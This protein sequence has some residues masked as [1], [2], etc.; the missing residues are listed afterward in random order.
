MVSPFGLR[1]AVSA[2]LQESTAHASAPNGL[3][4]CAGSLV[5]SALMRNLCRAVVVLVFAAGCAGADD[6]AGAGGGSTDPLVIQAPPGAW[7]WI[8]FEDAVCGNGSSTG[9]GVH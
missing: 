1:Q 5:F 7:T 2:V 4:L 8:P 9:L 6:P 3:A